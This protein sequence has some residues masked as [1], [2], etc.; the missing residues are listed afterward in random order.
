MTTVLLQLIREALWLGVVL[1]APILVAALAAG[2]LASLLRALTQLDDPSVA[3][4]LRVAAVVAALVLAGPSIATHAQAFGSRV[5]AMV[6]T[7]GTTAT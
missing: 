4:V 6:A 3:M 7:L 2:L 5:M 1:A